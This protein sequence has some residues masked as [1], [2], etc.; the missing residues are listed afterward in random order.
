M[1]V[2][3]AGGAGSGAAAGAVLVH[4]AQE[5]NVRKNRETAPG[6]MPLVLDGFTL[7]N[8]CPFVKMTLPRWCSVTA[9]V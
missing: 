7:R 6:E 8:L 5:R 9:C 2:A 3:A 1:L 4:E